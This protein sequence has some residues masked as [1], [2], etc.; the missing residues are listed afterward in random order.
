MTFIFILNVLIKS[1]KYKIEIL[2]KDDTILSITI[3]SV[4]TKIKQVKDKSKN[5]KKFK[6]VEYKA[7]YTIKL[8]DSYNILSH[9]L[10]DLTNTYSTEVRKDIFPYTFMTEQTLFYVGPKPSKDY[11]NDDVSL[12][13]YNEIPEN[14]DAKSITLDYLEK[15]LVSLYQVISKFSDYIYLN[16]T[17]QLTESV[18]I[19]SLALKIYLTKFY[20]N[21]IPLIN[22]N[23]IYKDIKES[24]FGGITEVY[25]PYGED[26]YYYD[27]NSLYPYAALNPI[28]GSPCTFES[29]IDLPLE[30]VNNFFGFYYCKIKTSDLYIGLLPY[31]NKS[32]V[33]KPNGEWE[34]WYFSEE[35]KFA[36]LKGYAITVLKGYSFNKEYDVFKGYVEHFYNVKS[37]T[38]DNTEKAVS[39]S[40]LNNLL[41]QFGLDLDKSKTNIFT[42][43]EFNK[44]VQTKDVIAFHNIGDKIFLNYKNKVNQDIC[45]SLSVDYKEA[46]LNSLIN[47]EYKEDPFKDVSI[48]IASAVTAYARIHMNKVKLDI[49]DKGGLIYYS[50]TDSIVTNK[51]LDPS[52]IGPELGLFKLEYQ[53]K[54][55]NFISSK[56]YCLA[57]NEATPIKVKGVDHYTLIKAKGV[58]NHKLSEQD[59][60]YLYKGF[61]IKTSRTES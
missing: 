3:K 33:I 51:A 17:V 41:G 10:E 23:T 44:I 5:K 36:A 54:R 15:D 40:L 29:N 55:G 35:L 53:V 9:K 58:N 37:T 45:D 11:Y 59:F 57:L 6:E 18:T 50:D 61:D 30:K 49:L 46:V 47:K 26:L 24:Y 8:V 19:S 12:T 7:N 25:K 27:V 48:A 38:K 21:N 39:K 13:A 28:P 31:R 20:S 60:I 43:E 2:S 52:E 16:H 22:Q 32:G 34:G 14:W 4:F 1:N 56:T 42:E